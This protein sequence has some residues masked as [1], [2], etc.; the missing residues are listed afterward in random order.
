MK[1]NEKKIMY[2]VLS[3]SIQII[4]LNHQICNKRLMI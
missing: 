3:E 4:F 1:K 2:N